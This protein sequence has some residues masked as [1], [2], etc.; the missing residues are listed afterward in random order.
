[1]INVRVPVH[2]TLVHVMHVGSIFCPVLSF[3]G[4]CNGEGIQFQVN[5]VYKTIVYSDLIFQSLTDIFQTLC[6]GCNTA[7]TAVVLA[8]IH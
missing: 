2:S 1:M 3:V 4:E 5:I 6:A 7:Q 8:V